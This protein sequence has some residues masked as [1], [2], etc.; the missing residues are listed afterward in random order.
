MIVAILFFPASKTLS[1]D[2]NASQ[3][4]CI[5]FARFFVTPPMASFIVSFQISC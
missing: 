2:R 4:C 3:H 5:G 1:K